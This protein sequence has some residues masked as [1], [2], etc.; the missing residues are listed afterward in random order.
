MKAYSVLDNNDTLICIFLVRLN[1]VRYFYTLCVW[2]FEFYILYLYQFKALGLH[3]VYCDQRL[4]PLKSD[5]ILPVICGV[6]VTRSN[7]FFCFFL[8]VFLF[9]LLII[10]I[11]SSLPV[12]N[13]PWSPRFSQGSLFYNKRQHVQGQTCNL[14]NKNHHIF[15]NHYTQR[16]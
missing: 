1:F 11:Y 6:R 3:T 14:H 4:S 16:K 15:I 12:N 7:L 8:F 9:F 10:Y 5:I 13:A 2:H